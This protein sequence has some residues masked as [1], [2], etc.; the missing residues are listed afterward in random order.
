MTT[1]HFSPDFLSHYN[2][3]GFHRTQKG[4]GQKQVYFPVINNEKQVLKKYMYQDERADRELEIYEKFKGNAGIPKI[5]LAEIYGTELVVFE[6]FIEGNTL[7][8]ITVSYANDA[9]LITKL[10]RD[11]FQIMTPIWEEKLV[12]RDIKPDNIMIKP[13]G[14]PIIIDFGI[15]RDLGANSITGTGMQPMTWM[16]ASPEQYAGE[17]HK[18]SYRTDFFSLGAL[19]Y[20][21]YYQKLPFGKNSAEI[22]DKFSNNDESFDIIDGCSLN[23]F[24][25]ESLKSSPAER[26]R[27][28]TDLTALL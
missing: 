22:A 25:K 2:I 14:T 1:Q 9:P 21:L 26:P 17:K 6:E 12:H 3:T 18:I 7:T 23:E 20:Y 5:I 8:D 28:I 16:F 11:I 19:A 27:L 4:G 10:M 13:D 24:C 15:A